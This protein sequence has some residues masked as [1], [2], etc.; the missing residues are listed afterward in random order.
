[1]ATDIASHRNGIDLS[2]YEVG[3]LFTYTPTD[4]WCRDGQA[5]LVEMGGARY[6]V[7]TYWG[8]GLEGILSL[9]QGREAEV[10]FVPSEYRQIPQHLAEV[11]GDEKVTITRRHSGHRVAYFVRNNE[12]HPTELDHYRHMLSKEQA[13]LAEHQRGV[14]SSQ[15]SID[16]MR[17]HIAH[18]EV[19][20]A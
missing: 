15:A 3:T 5:E 16:R 12:P 13:R 4:T 14:E 11:Y 10:S 2:Q 7:D 18:L 20:A 17:D 1:M 8:S 19:Q 9:E 6:L